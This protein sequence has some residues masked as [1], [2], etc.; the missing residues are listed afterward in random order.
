M[1]RVY[2]FNGFGAHELLNEN[3]ES[4]KFVII[5]SSTNEFVVGFNRLLND[6]TELVFQVI[7]DQLPIIMLDQEGNEWDIFGMAVAGPRV[8]Q[9]LAVLDRFI[10][11]WFAWATFYPN[12]E[13]ITLN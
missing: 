7:P 9:Q 11:Y 2:Q 12:A 10:A 4:Q 1:N 6:G 8:G 13:I 3:V 5:G